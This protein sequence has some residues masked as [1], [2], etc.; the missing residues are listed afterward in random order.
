MLAN[1]RLP[2]LKHGLQF[3]GEDMPASL[4]LNAG[5]DNCSCAESSHRHILSC[6]RQQH[7]PVE[8]NHSLVQG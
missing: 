5:K 7:A 6:Q 4:G 1:A 3:L 2:S 8:A